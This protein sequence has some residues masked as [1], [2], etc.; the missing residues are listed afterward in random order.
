MAEVMRLVEDRIVGTGVF[1]CAPCQTKANDQDRDDGGVIV[2]KSIEQF[3]SIL[4]PTC[5][6]DVEKV[7]SKS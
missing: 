4:C 6:F 3:L 7:L 2:A 1:L 5:K